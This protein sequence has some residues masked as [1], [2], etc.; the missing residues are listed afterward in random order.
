VGKFYLKNSLLTVACLFVLT[1]CAVKDSSES[2]NIYNWGE[3]MDEG[4]LDMFTQKTGITVNYDTY[5]TNEDMYTKLKSGGVSYDIAIPSDYMIQR[6]IKED[7][8][9]AI[10]MD[11][12]PNYANIDSRFKYLEYDPENKYSVPYMWGTVGI[13]YNTTMV[14]GPVESWD[15]LWEETY[16]DKIFM[17]DSMRDSIGITLK[18]LG[19][20]L[21]T[22]DVAELDAAKNELIKQK[23]IVRAL[24]GDTVRDSMIGDE[25]ALAVVYSGDAVYCI[26]ENPNLAYSVP[27]EGSNV[28][29]D[30]IVIPKDAQNISGA[31][32]FIDFLC[33]PEVCKKNVQ[34][35][36]YSTVNSETFKLLP[37]EM[38][39]DPAYWAGDEVFANCEI[40]E[41]LGDFV[42]EY[43]RAWTEYLAAE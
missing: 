8:L 23:P 33:D 31:E 28:W 16:A 12:I 25:A 20:S 36:G 13:L 3:Y 39:S 21:N 42:S 34:Y 4:I 41:D 38:V 19:Y 27:M 17:Y 1:A 14:S 7:L 40:F 2:I 22:R 29:F 26:G 15:I 18:R 10:D 37:Q 9:T 5:A 24:L 43:D 35:I 30:A 6:M 32:M 11:N